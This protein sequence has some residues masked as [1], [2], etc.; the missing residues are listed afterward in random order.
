LPLD[1]RKAYTKLDWEIWTASMATRVEDFAA[2]VDPIVAFLNQVPQRNPMTDWY[3][4]DDGREVGFRARS[5]VGGVF[6]KALSDPELWTKWATWDKNRVTQWAPFPPQ[7]IIR[8]IVTTSQ[9][10]ATNWKYV[11][12]NPG[13]LWFEV[14]YSD[15]EWKEG[16]APFASPNTPGIRVGTEWKTADIWMRRSFEWPQTVG[17]E[18]K[19]LI[20]HDE[21]AEIYINGVSAA[22]VN[23]FA[24]SYVFVPISASAIKTLKPGK[25]ILAVHCHQTGGGQ[26][27]DVGIATETPGTSAKLLAD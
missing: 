19:L 17:G 25:N 3:G 24:T 26:G 13:D 14:N 12:D 9:K 7:P 6:M 5:V 20:Y 2:L 22:K 21:D 27:V 16:P 11:I 1:S 23:G 4:T 8:E 10:K 15:K 18:A